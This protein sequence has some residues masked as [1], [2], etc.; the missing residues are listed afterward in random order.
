MATSTPL[1][2]ALLEFLSSRKDE[3]RRQAQPELSRFVRW[4]GR[5]RMTASLLPVELEQYAQRGI[6]ANSTNATERLELVREFLAFIYRKKYSDHNLAT[7]VRLRKAK[8]I[9]RPSRSGASSTAVQFTAEGLARLTQELENLKAQ[10]Q[11]VATEIQRAAADK[12][13]RE[14]AP[15]EAARER[16]GLLEAR[17]RELETSLKG[18][19]T[20]DA[21]DE[22]G[23]SRVAKQV[24]LGAKVVLRDTVSGS[25]T[26]Y[27]IVGAR[28]ASPLEGKL[29]T[30]SPV[31]KALLQ[32]RE[33]D[34]V[35]VTAPRGMITYVI[36]SIL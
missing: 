7:H 14:N 11:D 27:Q 15:L 23:A 20:L 30:E 3:R 12:D 28:E 4:Y 24:K 21:G 16:Q 29:S 5:D 31:G 25:E 36:A 18:A 8:A 32:R 1:H 22:Q 33:G 10:R 34:E 6:A 35:K 26:T 13:V 19:V 17:I 9:A 2:D